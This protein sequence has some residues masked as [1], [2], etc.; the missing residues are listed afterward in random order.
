MPTPRPGLRRRIARPETK[1][2]ALAATEVLERIPLRK[3]ISMPWL[4]SAVRPKSSAFTTSCFFPTGQTL[5]KNS[6][7]I[8]RRRPRIHGSAPGLNMMSVP[9]T[10]SASVTSVSADAAAGEGV[11]FGTA[12][13]SAPCDRAAVPR[14]SSGE[15]QIDETCMR[16]C[17]WDALLGRC[18]TLCDRVTTKNHVC[19]TSREPQRPREEA[20]IDLRLSRADSATQERAVGWLARYGASA[21]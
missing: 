3:A 1:A 21:G 9:D 8:N 7:G 11:F 20:D 6:T 5:P 14:D 4:I 16:F 2:G 18:P 10:P 12:Q 17:S 15:R 19:R 13:C